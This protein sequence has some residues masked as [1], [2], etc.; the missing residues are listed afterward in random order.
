[1]RADAGGMMMWLVLGCFLLSPFVVRHEQ[2]SDYSVHVI[3]RKHIEH[4][5][6]IY[7]DEHCTPADTVCA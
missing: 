2:L 1:M 4:Y 7:T 3:K 6:D 5:I